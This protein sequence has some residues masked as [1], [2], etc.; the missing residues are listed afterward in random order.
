MVARWL[1]VLELVPIT[2][3]VLAGMG[4][5]VHLRL[6][7]QSNQMGLGLGPANFAERGRFQSELPVIGNRDAQHQAQKNP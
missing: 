3:S 4:F 1:P 6:F 7:I 5:L 2:M